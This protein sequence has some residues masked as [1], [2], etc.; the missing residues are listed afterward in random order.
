MQS[1]PGLPH[2]TVIR[3]ANPSRLCIIPSITVLC[4]GCGGTAIAP[5]NRRSFPFEGNYSCR[6]KVVTRCIAILATALS[7]ISPLGLLDLVLPMSEKSDLAYQ[8][9]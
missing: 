1:H 7:S 5:L 4:P 3:T 2:P 9:L 8:G 6:N